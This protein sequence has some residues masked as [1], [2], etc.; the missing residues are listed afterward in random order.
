[1]TTFL[2]PV[3]SSHTFLQSFKAA[4]CLRRG[5]PDRLVAERLVAE[6]FLGDFLG[7]LRADVRFLD[8]LEDER[9]F[10]GDLRLADFFEAERF[11]VADLRFGDL[12]FVDLEDERLCVDDFLLGERFLLADLG[13]L[14]PDLLELVDRGVLRPDFLGLAERFD[15]ER[16]LEEELRVSA[17]IKKL[18]VNYILT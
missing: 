5:L 18:R 12:R 7:D 2:S 4:F 1:M 8:F 17:M 9:F 13:V 11:F 6:R 3:C 14:R 16:F 15:A 10:V